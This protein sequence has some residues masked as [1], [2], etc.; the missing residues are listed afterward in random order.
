MNRRY[1]AVADKVD[2]EEVY[3]LDE[4][5]E[6]V[7]ETATAEFDETVEVAFN[8]GVNPSQ[9]MV[10][11]S[12]VLPNGTGKEVTVLAFAKGEARREAEEAGA[13]YLGDDETVER[14]EDGWLDFDEVVATPDMMSVIGRLGRILGPRG[15]MPSPK[16]NTVSEDIGE[17]V[18]R[19]KKGQVEFK[20]DK[21]GVVH[22]PVGKA[23][24]SEPELREN[25]I[26]LA[27]S[28]YDERPEEGV[29]ARYVQKITISA[30]MGPGL[31]LSV[32][33]LR[34]TVY[35]RRL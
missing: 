30:T 17:A 22:V 1:R 5:L 25:L 32:E 2:S 3:S 35:E 18:K 11:G 23:S 34:E 4:G 28:I 27:K 24:F 10:R 33:E 26:E 31:K 29:D 7:K 16:S 9:N 20:V 14:I 6:L 13:D 8:L 15:L 21:Y 19:L 12:T